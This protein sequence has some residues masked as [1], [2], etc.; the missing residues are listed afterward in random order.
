MV[1]AVLCFLIGIFVLEEKHRKHSYLQGYLMYL[2]L[3]FSTKMKLRNYSKN[4]I[5]NLENKSGASTRVDKKLEVLIAT[6]KTTKVEFNK[7][8]IIYGKVR[9]IRP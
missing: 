1:T 9:A 6:S 8:I 7:F 4:Y 3:S 5:T 2:Y